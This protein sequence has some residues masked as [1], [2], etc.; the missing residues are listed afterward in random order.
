MDLTYRITREHA[1]VALVF[2]LGLAIRMAGLGHTPLSE[3]EAQLALQAL[4]VANGQPATISGPPL[5]VMLT[6]FTFYL[7]GSSDF[8]ARFWPALFGSLLVLAPVLYREKLGALP[9]VLFALGIAL[10]PA[11]AAVSR[12]ANGP[13]T[14]LAPLVLAWGLLLNRRY[15]AGG[16]LAGLAALSGPGLVMGLLILALTWG[17]ATLLSRRGT[18]SSPPGAGLGQWWADWRPVVLTTGITAL[19]VGS[20]FGH[21]PQGLSAGLGALPGFLT[22]WWQPSG[23]PALRVLSALLIY[24]PIALL[25]ALLGLARRPL[26]ASSELS[27]LRIGFLIALALLILSPGRQMSALAWALLPL[28]ALAASELAE[29]TPLLQERKTVM[30][31]LAAVLF[32]IAAMFWLNLSN[33]SLA[34]PAIQVDTLRLGLLGGLLALAVVS[35]VLVG[36]GWS[37]QVA[38]G[39]VVLGLCLIYI[40]NN[41]ANLAGSTQ[42]RQAPH[43]ELW[44]PAPSAGDARLLEDTI[45]QLSIWNTGR[46]EGLDIQ[47]AVQSSALQWLLR[48]YQQVVFLGD[49]PA[50]S[51]GSSPS[52]VIT[53]A[54]NAEPS[55]AAAYRGQ[56]FAWWVYPAWSGVLP[57]PFFRWLVFREAALSQEQVILW[58]RADLF[59]GQ[60]L[61]SLQ[62]GSSELL[63][64]VVPDQE[65]LP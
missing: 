22:A 63:E 61:P 35:T 3:A 57:E 24:Q 50:L 29:S 20:Y 47:V 25:F 6:G 4:T 54:Q 42:P 43:V 37:W 7:L 45:R 1:V 34:L 19:L 60:T 38:R 58:A 16:V 53:R 39:G 13:L 10:D 40:V 28:W 12:Q 62:D 56:D 14:A 64:N 65:Q 31:G 23:V 52:L 33:L 5:Y 26:Q 8:L 18:A 17:A 51:A 32:I 36:M 15:L 44:N 48:G 41:A 21:Y 30:F 49:T 55:L 59:P 46:A 27:L 11:L 9:A 2:L